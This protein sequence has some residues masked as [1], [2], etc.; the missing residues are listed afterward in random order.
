MGIVKERL[1]QLEKE[2]LLQ[3]LEDFAKRW[4]AHDGLW[5]QA[6]E[7]EY[8]LAAA[9]AADKAA[10]ERFTVI[11]AERIMRLLGIEPGGGIPALKEA[12]GLRLYALVNRQEIVEESEKRMIFRM[13]ECRVQAA[14]KRKGMAAFP[15]KEVALWNI[16]NLPGLLANVSLPGVYA[17]LPMIIR[18]ITTAPGSLSWY[19]RRNTA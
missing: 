8:G 4:L 1:R 3:L 11:E 7:H 2:Q 10:W 13:R 19:R 5:F 14:R 15:C 6:V 17:A 18:K 16:V 12:L 9:I